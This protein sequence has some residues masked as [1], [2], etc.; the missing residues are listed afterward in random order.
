MC[1][2]NIVTLYKNKGD[3]G[4]YNN[5]RGISLP[6]RTRTDPMDDEYKEPATSENKDPT[7]TSGGRTGSPLL[8]KGPADRCLQGM[9]G[10]PKDQRVEEEAASSGPVAEGRGLHPTPRLAAGGAPVGHGGVQQRRGTSDHGSAA[11]WDLSG[12][13]W[14]RVLRASNMWIGLFF[15]CKLR[16]NI[17]TV[18]L[19]LCKIET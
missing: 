6:P 13:I 19:W 2:N 1:N 4:D 9:F 12:L 5:C 18:H 15:L 8:S 11:T 17:A 16:Q 3:C 10:S 14:I 7:A